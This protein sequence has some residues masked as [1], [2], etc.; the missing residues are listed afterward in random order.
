MVLKCTR[1]HSTCVDK[2]KLAIRKFGKRVRELRLDFGWSQED[3]A[4]ELDVDRSYV[5]SLELG[6]RNPTLK[7]I[8]KLAD[9]LGVSISELFDEI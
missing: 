1:F 9:K 7:T 5:S 8:A 4:F 2:G 3:L 6:R